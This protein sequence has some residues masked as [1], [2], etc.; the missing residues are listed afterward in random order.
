MVFNKS[1]PVDYRQYF[2]I[3]GTL[4]Q[5]RVSM[6]PDTD[7]GGSRAGDMLTIDY[8]STGIPIV[9]NKPSR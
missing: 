5:K 2:A 7:I 3:K 1:F 9:K 6:I 4:S 8:A